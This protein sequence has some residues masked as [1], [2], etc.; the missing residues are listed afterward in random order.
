MA[1]D[2]TDNI[3][4]AA[5]DGLDDLGKMQKNFAA[6][7]SQF[8]GAGAPPNPVA[9]MP[10]VDQTRH[11][12]CV[13][14]EANTAW[15][16]IFDMANGIPAGQQPAFPS[17]TRLAFQQ[18]TAPTGWT[19]DTAAAINDSIL[20]LVT[21]TVGSGGSTAFSS[22]NGQSATGATTLSTAQMPSHNHLHMING[23]IGGSTA[24]WSLAPRYDLVYPTAIST[25]SA[26]GGGS[27]T[28]PLTHSIKYYDFVIASKD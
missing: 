18:T 2:F 20:R 5:N 17:G 14:N 13:R 4:A 15:Q 7:K 8:S 24:G 27:H 19:K 12:F 11:M 28:H 25:S 9:G 6:L 21:G 1:Q 26:G 23:E 16:D 22:F 3:P 10:W